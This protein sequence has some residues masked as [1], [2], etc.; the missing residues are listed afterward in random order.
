MVPARVLLDRG[1]PAL[2]IAHVSEYDGVGRAGLG[3]SGGEL[4][5]PDGPVLDPRLV[6]RAPDALDAEGALL[7]DAAR[8]DGHVRVELQLERLWPGDLVVLVPVEIADLVGAVVGAV[9]GAHAAVVD[10]AVQA[11]GGVI[12]RVDRADRLARRV[13]AVLAEHRDEPRRRRRAGVVTALPVPLDAHP[14]DLPA[15][16]DLLLA[17]GR[18]VVLRVAGRDARLAAGAARQVDR[19][20]P[21]RQVAGVVPLGGAA[22]LRLG[23]ALERLHLPR[24]VGLLVL[25]L[26]LAEMVLLERL[27]VLRRGQRHGLGDA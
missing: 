23:P 15:L 12:G 8:P 20:A 10:L 2:G 9:A 17:H 21:L 1:H 6:L 18:D 22:V 5:V 13:A 27:A 25:A 11:V 16:E 4:A 24:R 3:A 19:H 14:G 26:V 7:H